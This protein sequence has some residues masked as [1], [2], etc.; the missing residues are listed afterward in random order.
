MALS[1]APR[2]RSLREEHA[3][4]ST[5]GVTRAQIFTRAC[6]VWQYQMKRQE[7]WLKISVAE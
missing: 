2:A 3:R 7:E 5:R 6:L 4:P 1:G